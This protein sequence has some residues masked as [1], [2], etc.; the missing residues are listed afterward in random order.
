M[1]KGSRGEKEIRGRVN[2]IRRS[3]YLGVEGSS[4]GDPWVRVRAVMLFCH[5]KHSQMRGRNCGCSCV[6]GCSVVV[7]VGVDTVY[8]HQ[9]G[10]LRAWPELGQS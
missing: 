2:R 7:L 8:R 10:V 5:D 9:W 1:V 3:D 4:L 6:A